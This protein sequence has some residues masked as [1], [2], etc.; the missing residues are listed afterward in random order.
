MNVW[1][2]WTLQ[3]SLVYILSPI[4]LKLVYFKLITLDLFRAKRVQNRQ[5]LAQEEGPKDLIL[6][7]RTESGPKDPDFRSEYSPKYWSHELVFPH[8]KPKI[9]DAWPKARHFYLAFCGE[10]LGSFTMTLL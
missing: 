2:Y 8:K 1:Y 6:G 7:L 10:I 9:K 5:I 3:I 4:N